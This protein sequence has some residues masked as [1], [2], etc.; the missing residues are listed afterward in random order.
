MMILRMSALLDRS[1][2]S[3]TMEMISFTPDVHILM[4]LLAGPVRFSWIAQK[5]MAKMKQLESES[6]D[7][8]KMKK[9]N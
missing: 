8:K 6:E 7:W 2:S 1:L 5:K 9:W 4:T 3:G